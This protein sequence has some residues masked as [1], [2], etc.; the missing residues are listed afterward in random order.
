MGTNQSKEE[1]IISQAGNS[2][3]TSGGVTKPLSVGEIMGI[4][5][6]C[7]DVVAI[8]LFIAYRVKKSMEQKIRKEIRRGQE[9]I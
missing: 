5:A 9:L 6:F 2:G 8:I 4:V 3:S 1:V 7:L